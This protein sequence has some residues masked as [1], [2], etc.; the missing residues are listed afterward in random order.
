MAAQCHRTFH[1]PDCVRNLLRDLHQQSLDQEALLKATGGGY[2]QLRQASKDN[3]ENGRKQAAE[4]M[5]DKFI[6]LE[7]D[8]A[9]FVYH[10]LRA[11]GAL[12]VVEAGTSYGVS[13][14][15]LATAVGQNA[16][17]VGKNPGEAKVIATEHG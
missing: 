17:D 13:T 16:T 11:T 5:Q 4:M 9:L 8:K 12:N 15:Y 7:E 2:D 1:A 14:I 10:L 6:A 3:P